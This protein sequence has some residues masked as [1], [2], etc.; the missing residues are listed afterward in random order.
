MRLVQVT[1]VSGKISLVQDPGTTGD[2]P[3]S[4]GADHDP[5]TLAI[6]AA[7]GGGVPQIVPSFE[8]TSDGDDFIYGTAGNDVLIG[9]YGADWISGGETALDRGFPGRRQPAW[10]PEQ[11]TDRGG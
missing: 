8:D 1:F 6:G 2:A 10:H 11:C 7:R 3:L 5:D 4:G 9:G